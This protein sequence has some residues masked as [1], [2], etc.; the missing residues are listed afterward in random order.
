[1]AEYKDCFIGQDGKLYV[2]GIREKGFIGYFKHRLRQFNPRIIFT[3]EEAKKLGAD[4]KKN[5]KG[6]Y[7]KSANGIRVPVDV[8]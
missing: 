4:Y 8:I 7:V 5:P 6:F 3:K 2:G 1:M